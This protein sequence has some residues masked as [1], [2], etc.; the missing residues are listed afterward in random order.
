MSF[1]G[2]LAAEMGRL[3]QGDLSRQEALIAAFGL[4]P[5]PP[6]GIDIDAIR[7]AMALD[8][9]VE[10][11]KSRWV[12]LDRIGH[13]QLRGDVDPVIADGLLARFFVSE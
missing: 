12:L 2:R 6:D 4:P 1:A 9:K 11:G 5:R 3:S 7:T 8:K 10:S 13:A